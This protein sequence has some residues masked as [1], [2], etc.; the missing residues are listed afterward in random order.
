[1]L[2]SRST[3]D[4]IERKK[5]Q[6]YKDGGF[7]SKESGNRLRVLKIKT[8]LASCSTNADNQ[9]IPSTWCNIPMTAEYTGC[10]VA[11]I[12]DETHTTPLMKN[13]PMRT[14]EPT[15]KIHPPENPCSSYSKFRY[16]L[17]LCKRQGKT[18]PATFAA[19]IDY[20]AYMRPSNCDF[21]SLPDITTG[22]TDPS[23]P[24]DPSGNTDFT[25]SSGNTTG[26]Y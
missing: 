24:T 19:T 8:L 12:V 9:F 11:H 1:M 3:G 10:P 7:V 20:P 16:N 21:V 22:E 17:K 2:Y 18:F 14:V 26:D 23:G 4:Y 6:N 15:K 13:L 25:D 5:Y